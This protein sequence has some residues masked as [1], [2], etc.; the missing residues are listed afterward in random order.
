M[1]ALKSVLCKELIFR[2]NW[3]LYAFYFISNFSQQHTILWSCVGSD[4]LL[5]CSDFF[6]QKQ[7][8]K[9]SDLT[10]CHIRSEFWLGNNMKK[11]F[12]QTWLQRTLGIPNW[13]PL[14]T[15]GHCLEVALCYKNW[16]WDSIMVAAVG[17]WS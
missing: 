13:L 7:R 3:F 2:W 9:F 12:S 6:I 5:T 14:L 16:N 10:L 8:L 1:L 15:G 17:R 4:V 11:Q